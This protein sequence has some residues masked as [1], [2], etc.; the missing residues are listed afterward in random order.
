MALSKQHEY[1]EKRLDEII[2]EMPPF[3]VEYVDDKW[4]HR[5]PLTLFNYVRDFQS[6]FSWL[7]SEGLVQCESIRTFPVE[8]LATLS[9]NDVKNYFK[10]LSRKKYE[11]GNELQKISQKTVNRHLSALRPS[12]TI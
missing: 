9:L 10:S 2:K 1:Y 11:K 6:F 12:S 3:V 4:D 8:A 5:S 7:M